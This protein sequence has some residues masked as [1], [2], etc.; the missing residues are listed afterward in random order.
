MTRLSGELD[1]IVRRLGRRALPFAFAVA[2]LAFSASAEAYVGVTG[3]L[4]L[5]QG[6]SAMRRLGGASVRVGTY[7]SETCAVE[8][9]VGCAENSAVFGFGVLAHAYGWSLYDRYFGFSAFDPF[10]TL[11]ARGWIGSTGG[12]VGPSAGLGAFYHL[13]DNWSL[14]AEA[15]VTVGLDTDVEA[16][17]LLSF[18]VQ[19]SF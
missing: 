15:D 17:S 7:L 16:V 8:G 4:V 5:P 2:L 10:V 9:S 6:G 12:Q 19:Y 1:V 14:R 18:G 13:D 3:D 11:C